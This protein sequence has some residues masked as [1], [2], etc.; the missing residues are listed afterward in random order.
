MQVSLKQADFSLKSADVEVE[1]EI[2]KLLNLP[3]AESY[4]TMTT[5]LRA[6]V[7]THK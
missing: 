6:G 5:A 3:L 7:R 1:K 2:E 4:S